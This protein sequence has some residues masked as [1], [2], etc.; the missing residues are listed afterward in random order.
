MDLPAAPVGLKE[1][2]YA[3]VRRLERRRAYFF[4]GCAGLSVAAAGGALV[5]LASSAATSGFASYASL[6]FSGDIG[7]A[8]ARDLSYALLE[9]APLM[10]VV[11]LLAF[12]GASVAAS[13]LALSSIRRLRVAV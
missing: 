2:I 8:L 6:M 7:P 5:L 10:S 9:S 13:A 11:A 4:A 1:R 3:A 12:T